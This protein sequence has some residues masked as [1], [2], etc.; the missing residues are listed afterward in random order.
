MSKLRRVVV[1]GFVA[2]VLVSASLVGGGEAQAKAP[3][4]FTIKAG[5]A[6][7]T[8]RNAPYVYTRY[9]P[10]IARVHRGQRIRWS[11]LQTHSV[12]FSK[13]GRPGWFRADEVPN[14]YAVNE[15]FGF[16]AKN[17]G[18]GD[19][20]PCPLKSTTTFLSSGVSRTRQEQPFEIVVDA[21]PGTYKYFCTIHTR[22]T[23][24]IQ[25]VGDATPVPTA[26]AVSSQVAKDVLADSKA[27]DAVFRADQ[28]PVS[29]VNA[30]QR[31]WRGLLG[32]AT[33]DGHVSI[34]A[35]MPTDLKIGPG[36]K[37]HYV[38]RDYASNEPH[39]VTFPTEVTGGP[40]GGPVGLGTFA[41]FPACDLDDP[42]SGVRGIPGLWGASPFPACPGNLEILH[43]PWM[44]TGHP[45]RN[46]EVATP[47]TYHDSGLLLPQRADRGMRV[48]PD[49]GRVLPSTFDAQFPNAGTFKFECNLHTDVMT[50]SINV[51]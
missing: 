42:S 7:P 51:A 4:V 38:F 27:A 10:E 17:C 40:P 39:T 1:A 43:A 44:T 48:L 37:V 15:R 18:I 36:D 8:N 20:A 45:A 47:A 19:L 41:L 28:K 31:V 34:V 11:F 26:S 13:A 25:V 24:A 5:A 33:R 30:G 49:T 50:G 12:T 23:G 35:F 6:H 2:G 3:A 21:L 14:T 9:Y 22:M 46:D 29:T 32:D 16:G